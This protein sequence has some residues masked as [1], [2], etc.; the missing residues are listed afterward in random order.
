MLRARTGRPAISLAAL[1][2]CVVALCSGC[3]AAGTASAATTSAATTSAA[4]HADGRV[5][6]VTTLPV[7]TALPSVGCS[8]PAAPAVTEQRVTIS[9]NGAP[10]W[11]LLTT[12]APA[13]PVTP[14]SG[15]SQPTAG[16]PIP[17]PL[18]LDFHG[19]D[20]GAVLHATTTQFGALGQQD[21]FV[22]V[23]PNGSGD[24]VQWDT[25]SHA[26]T[27]HD[28]LFVKTLLAQVEAT[29]CIDT[30]RVY[31][32]GFS[33]GS[34]MVSMLA[35]TMSGTFAAI[36]AVSGLQLNPPCHTTRR[37]PVITFHG[38]ADPIL[39]FN[40][41]IGTSTLERLIGLSGSAGS[42]TTTTT[43]PLQLNGPG[44][45]AT[46]RAWAAK[47][48][49]RP[50][51]TN[52]TVTQGVVLRSYHCPADTAVEFYI[53]LGGGHSWPGSAVSQSLSSLT[54]YTTMAINATD[55]MWSFFQRFRV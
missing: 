29:Q 47:D 11:Y 34:F 9:V 28:L 5:P 45:P 51:S 33:D 15:G 44:V 26:A 53:I 17:R 38:T 18:V 1:V 49:C 31:A 30:S 19:L 37:V 46:V 12:P 14:A 25:T 4:T 42:T 21:G 32:S 36:G 3:T 27:N 48:G 55:L 13:T 52:T 43:Q 22:A 16:S 8:H 23:F 20:E 6:S 40:G 2:T 35:C 7:H 39:F 10:R 41:G 50:T 54:G 24:P